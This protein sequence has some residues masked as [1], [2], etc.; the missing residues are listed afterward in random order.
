SHIG[1]LQNE[2]S[3]ERGITQYT[4]E[5][6]GNLRTRTDANGNTTTYTYDYA[7]RLLEMVYN[8]GSEYDVTYIYDN[9][10][11][12]RRITT[13]QVVK[14]YG[15]DAMNRVTGDTLQI[16]GQ[17][18]RVSY[19]YDGN[20]NLEY[21]TYPDETVVQYTYD[22]EN[23]VLTIPGYIDNNITYHPSG[24]ASLFQ[25]SNGC[26]TSVTF[27]DDRYFVKR[28]QITPYIMDEEYDYDQSGNL[29]SLTDHLNGNNDQV[30]TY[31][32][33]HRLE[34]FLSTNYSTHM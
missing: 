12:V 18:F 33:F 29:T 23:R 24:S 20:G 4:Y 6:N 1:L 10:D 27:H 3:P 19:D 11:N 15:Y 16:D 32:D 8:G 5:N 28:I 2:S 22:N 14:R 7:N 30:F 34:Q 9:A 26:Q 21:I 13:P 25:T 17:E 31:D